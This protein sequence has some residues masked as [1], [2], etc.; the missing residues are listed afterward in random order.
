MLEADAAAL[1]VRSDAVGGAPA[2]CRAFLGVSL[3]VESGRYGALCFASGSATAALTD[4]DREFVRAVAELA[5]VSIQR[6]NE[7]KR[8]VGLAHFDVLTGLP[9]RLLLD[10]RFKQAIATAQR[11]GEPLTVYYID[12]DKFK[13]VNDTHGHR[14]GDEVLR[15]VAARLLQACRASDTVARLGGDEFVVLR[16]GP[17]AASRPDELASRLRAAL[18][19]PCDIEDLHLK[20]SAG[21]GISVFPQDG[22]DELTLLESADSALYAAKAGGAGSIRRFGVEGWAGALSAAGLDRHPG[23]TAPEDP[24]AAGPAGTPIL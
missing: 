6:A 15:A 16:S 24:G 21:I 12:V 5:A 2:F 14:I 4:F 13:A 11:R 3:D 22:N 10:D 7:D 9:N 20:L 17:F 23:P 8:L 18:E 1:K 19:A